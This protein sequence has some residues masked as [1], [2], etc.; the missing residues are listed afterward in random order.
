[1]STKF[2]KQINYILIALVILNILDGDFSNPS[3]L[4]FIKFALLGYCLYLNTKIN[5]ED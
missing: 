3:I 5:R 1:M 4:D 2:M